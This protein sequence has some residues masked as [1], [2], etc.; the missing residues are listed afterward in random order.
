MEN[1]TIQ[2]KNLSKIILV[3]LII[4]AFLI[5]FSLIQLMNNKK[6][7]KNKDLEIKPRTTAAK[8]E[9]KNEVKDL[10]K[11]VV[12]KISRVVYDMA[13]HNNKNI[14]EISYLVRS[15]SR[16]ESYDQDAQFLMSS[17]IVDVPK[18]KQSYR[19]S[20]D[21]N[22]DNSKQSDSIY[23]YCLTKEEMIYPAFNCY[24]LG[25]S[26]RDSAYT[27]IKEILPI[28]RTVNGVN[29]NIE[30]QVF[31]SD[32]SQPFLKITGNFC[33]NETLKKKVEED[34]LNLA[35][36][37]GINKNRLNYQFNDNCN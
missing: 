35:K 8:I 22:R 18:L 30:N 23:A 10:P 37:N 5:G 11:D 6:Q 19:I 21:N 33:N 2:K 12:I 9:N 29:Y 34:F 16:K 4:S 17:L 32:N 25:E 20:Y 15:G 26:K 27:T 28:N 14:D 7:N 1:E 36:E 13:E 31:Y 24:N 3:I